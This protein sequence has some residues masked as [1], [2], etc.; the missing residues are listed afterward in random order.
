M[1][2]VVTTAVAEVLDA[3]R[4]MLRTQ[5]VWPTP[6]TGFAYRV[7]VQ[8][9]TPKP[10]FMG[11][12]LRTTTAALLRRTPELAAFGYV[13]DRCSDATIELWVDAVEHLRGRDIYPAD[14]QSFIFNPIEILGLAQGLVCCQMA[15]DDHRE[16]FA[17]TILRGIKGNQFRTSLSTLAAITALACIDQTKAS[18]VNIGDLGLESLATPELVLA[19]GIDL[20]FGRHASVDREK[21]QLALLRRVFSER[22]AIND[23]A[24]AATLAIV[25]QHIIDGIALGSADTTPIER[26]LGLC[27]RFPLF[28]ER[29]Q[30]R[31]RKRDSFP[32]NDEYDVQDLLHAILK[33]HFDDVRPEEYTPS[34][35][36]NASKVDFYLPPER[37]VVEAKMTRAN[38]GQREVT[39]QLIIDVA[40]Y[41]QMDGV[42]SLVCL[43]YDPERRCGNPKAV[44]SD[45]ENSGSRLTVRAVICPQGL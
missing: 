9:G 14:R 31:Q 40:R 6:G 33:L 22:I 44:E 26:V 42:D 18:T 36:G 16:W 20:G 28:V 15:T 41:S 23:A 4:Q 8:T 24:E 3:A 19:A 13:A 45:V 35:S 12:P 1:N 38:L 5:M 37:L 17:N 7:F 39:D 29:L 25:V 32:V 10:E 2:A 34:Y 27:R 11:E 43:I 21:V 30:N